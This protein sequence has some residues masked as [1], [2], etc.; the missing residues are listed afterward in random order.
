MGSL[1]PVFT[2]EV[3]YWEK[4]ILEWAQTYQLDPNLVAVVMQIESCGHPNIESHVGA[5]GLFQV[6]PF[7]FTKDEDPFKPDTNADRGLSYL[8]KA[9][10][11]A[12]N[13]PIL[14]LAGYNGGHGVISLDPSLWPD[15]TIRYVYWGSGIL[16]D[17]NNGETSSSRLNEWMLAGGK[18]LCV[19]SSLEL[20]L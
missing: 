3:Q 10:I 4:D 20:G 18:S 13:D 14:A 9:L 7:H 5:K 16:V 12:S 2:D 1:S 6:M 15:E 19:L 17:I 8:S 11:L